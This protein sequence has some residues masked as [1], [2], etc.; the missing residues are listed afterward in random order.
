MKE[1]ILSFIYNQKTN[2]FL[3]LEIKR[4]SEQFFNREWFTVNG[5]M[6]KNETH[7]EAVNRKVIEETG[8]LVEKIFPLN[9]GSVYLWKGEEFKEMN[10]LSYVSNE[11]VV[12][13]GEYSDYKWVDFNKFIEKINWNDSKK[14]LRKVLEKAIVGEI[15]FNKKERGQ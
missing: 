12:L 15:F 2:K 14:L 10:F 5:I 11:K 3:L 9:W 4:D 8:L 13:T 7:E 1:K 6:E